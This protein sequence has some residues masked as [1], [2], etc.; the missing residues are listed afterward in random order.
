[1]LIRSYRTRATWSTS[2][3]TP[4]IQFLS[5]LI[6]N[7]RT[8]TQRVQNIFLITIRTRCHSL[9][10]HQKSVRWW[11][12]LLLSRIEDTAFCHYDDGKRGPRASDD[13]EQK[14]GVT[15]R[16]YACVARYAMLK[17]ESSCDGYHRSAWKGE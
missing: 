8:F 13:D 12:G 2:K 11:D 6:L 3:T 10:L 15:Y 7:Y 16:L 17:H 1:V 5:A 4:S 9:R 14:I